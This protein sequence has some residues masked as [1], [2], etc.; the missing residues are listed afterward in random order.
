M[1][2]QYPSMSTSSTSAIDAMIRR[3]DEVDDRPDAAALRA[4]SYELIHGPGPVADVGCGSGRAVAEL[5]DR[6]VR[7]IGVDLSEQMVAVARRRWP[8]ADIRVGDACALP[9]EDGELGGYRADKVLHNLH[10]PGRAVAEAHRVLAPGG[11]AVLVGQ[12]WGAFLIDSDRPVLTDRIVQARA[13]QL[14]SPYAARAQRRLLLDAGFRDVT[15][16]AYTGVFTGEEGLPLLSG[17]VEACLEAKV[18]SDDEAGAW[19]AEQ[20]D[21]A[22]DGRLF[23]AVPL[24]MA[25]GTRP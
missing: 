20:H 6:G 11:R 9:F 18:I 5:A 2:S 25:A 22:R 1:K 24:F 8:H 13:E 10:E 17:T 16:E 14:P 4:R 23:L 15:V 19:L 21:R 7:A 12:D 3:L